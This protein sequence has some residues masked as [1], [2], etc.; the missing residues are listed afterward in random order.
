MIVN[1]F[2]NLTR[3]RSRWIAL[4]SIA[5]A[6]VCCL[7]QDCYGQAPTR[8]NLLSTAVKSEAELFRQVGFHDTEAPREARLPLEQLQLE[9]DDGELHS[10][11]PSL[12]VG[13]FQP[14]T[15]AKLVPNPTVMERPPTERPLTIPAVPDIASPDNVGDQDSEQVQNPVPCL[16]RT[17]QTSRA[18]FS[19]NPHFN[20]AQASTG[21][22][23]AKPKVAAPLFQVQPKA[24]V[25]ESKS[26][27]NRDRK[28]S[29]DNRFSDVVSRPIKF[30]ETTQPTLSPPRSIVSPQVSDSVA[31]RA[32]KHIEYGKTLARR[33]AKSSAKQEFM[34]ALSIIAQDFDVQRGSMDHSQALRRGILALKES[35]EFVVNESESQIGMDVGS[36]IESHQ[37]GAISKEAAVGLNA[38]QALQRYFGFAQME[39][40]NGVGKNLIS[41]EA[42]Y[43][44]GRLHTLGDGVAGIQEGKL[45]RAR[46]MVYHRAALSCDPN[47]YR[48]ANELGVLLAEFG[49]LDE[50]IEVLKASLRIHPTSS[51][52]SNLAKVHQRLNQ[53][54]LA[55]LATTESQRT[56]PN[57]SGGIQW[58]ESQQFNAA[59]PVEVQVASN[60]SPNPTSNPAANPTANPTIEGQARPSSGRDGKSPMGTESKSLSE[61]FKSWF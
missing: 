11:Q 3:N 10:N 44:L 40:E 20:K 38:L 54:Q 43:C 39:I 14:A 37:C 51:T 6:M 41:A 7:E 48:S 50:S 46:A 8:P 53:Q 22:L 31:I 58:L 32:V 18:G 45:D 57:P 30:S 29:E 33:G 5:N 25:E 12:G 24:D 61:R 1:W 19:Q 36:L 42:L 17:N 21:K 52:W 35:E 13:Y 34:A 47:N 55:D 26:K 28:N 27:L 60:P 9:M 23:T 49:E 16:I 15:T 2:M 56:L 4:A 59:A